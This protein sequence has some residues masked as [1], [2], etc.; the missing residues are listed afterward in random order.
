MAEETYTF[1]DNPKGKRQRTEYSEEA[2]FTQLIISSQDKCKN[3]LTD[4]LTNL[5]PT[6]VQLVLVMYYIRISIGVVTH[7]DTRL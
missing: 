5:K 7:P 4:T 1:I 6:L 2:S 3:Y